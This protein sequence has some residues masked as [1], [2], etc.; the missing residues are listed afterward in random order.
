MIR[1][2][3]SD[4]ARRSQALYSPCEVYR[5]GLERRWDD[6]PAVLFVML[7]PSTATER[8][9]DAT[10]ERCERRA[11][12]LGFGAVLIGNLFAFRATRP[13]DLRRAP[14][15]VGPGN[16][17]ALAEMLARAD[18]A[19]AAW[20]VHGAYRHAGIDFARQGADL[21]H[22]GL[23]KAGHPRHPLYVSYQTNPMPWPKETR[24]VDPP[25]NG[26]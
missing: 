14:D 13:A 11:R 3:H 22:L 12:A 17:E 21:W 5:Y 8:H 24:Y 19:I 20:G 23:T 25:S 18:Q 2:A 15:P 4:G 26:A 9:N 6:G 7:N 1:R 10:I 16:A